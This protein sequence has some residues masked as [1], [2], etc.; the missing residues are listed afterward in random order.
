MQ[1]KISQFVVWGALLW[2]AALVTG[3]G[4]GVLLERTPGVPRFAALPIKSEIKVVETADALAQPV[5][6]VGT[7]HTDTTKGE[8]DRPQ[9]IV[10][11]SNQARRSGCD[12]LAGLTMRDE[13][14]TSQKSVER[15]GAGGAKVRAQETVE[16]HTFKWQAQCVRSALLDPGA[17]PAPHAAPPPAAEPAP[18]AEQ[19]PTTPE[20][21][22]AKE[23][24]VLL[25]ERK[26]F[27]RGMVDKLQ[28]PAP[29]PADVVDALVE[30][31]VQ[32]TGPTGLWRKT[33]PQEWFGCLAAADSPACLRLRDLERDLRHADALHSE[34]SGLS[35]G[36]SSGWLRRSEARVVE[37]LRTY[38]PL[39]ASLA[40]VQATPF[41]REKLADVPQ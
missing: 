10:A 26:V 18:A 23:I 1:N 24:A 29:D 36:Q 14:T 35:R 8:A 11:L 3:C 27:I 37:Y 39:E 6:V 21:K 25:I 4:P 34:A 22:T 40:G 16:R 32:V 38:V 33:M 2:A 5:T 28:R 30:T 41:Y 19:E 20:G 12:A 31:M 15:L 7:L 9:V 17:K 13:V